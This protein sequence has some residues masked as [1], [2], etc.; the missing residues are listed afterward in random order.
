M[1]FPWYI[2]SRIAGSYSS[3]IFSFLRNI[4]T[5]LHSGFTNLQSQ[6]KR[7]P[8]SP[9]PLHHSLFV[10]FVMMAILTSVRW[11]LT[12]VLICILIL[13]HVEHLFMCLLTICRS[14]LKK[15][16]IRYSACF[17]IGLLVCLILSCRSY[18]YIL[19]INPLPVASFANIF[20]HSQCCLLFC[21]WFP[22]LCK[23]F[24]V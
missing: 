2:P 10:E 16:L 22:L 1:V 14:S 18:L 23:S 12:V 19:E 15:S 13:S 5:V 6:Q 9:H 8:F 17:L 7:A 24:K 3:S 4:H 20:S 21:L 11:H